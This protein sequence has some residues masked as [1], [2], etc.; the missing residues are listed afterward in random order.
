KIKIN[1][2]KSYVAKKNGLYFNKTKSNK[3]RFFEF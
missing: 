1:Y 2:V 3:I